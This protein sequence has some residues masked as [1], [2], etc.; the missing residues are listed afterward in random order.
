MSIYVETS[1]DYLDVWGEPEFME[2]ME[3]RYHG[4][5][6][7]KGHRWL[8]QALVLEKEQLLSIKRKLVCSDDEGGG[9]FE[10]SSVTTEHQVSWEKVRAL[11]CHTGEVDIVLKVSEEMDER[12]LV[13]GSSIIACLVDHGFNG[14]ALGSVELDRWS[15]FFIYR[16]GLDVTV[17][18]GTSLINMYSRCGSIDEVVL[19]FYGMPKRN[20]IKGTTLITGLAVHGRSRESL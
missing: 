16:N 15:H 20:V 2:K 5:A 1:G 7:A 3:V 19:V 13:S 18:L 11:F 12:D 10:L 6:V 4:K 14:E 9:S 8:R 17:A